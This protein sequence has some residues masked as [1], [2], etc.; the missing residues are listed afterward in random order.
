MFLWTSLIIDDML[1]TWMLGDCWSALSIDLEVVNVSR[2]FE[3]DD[4]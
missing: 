2:R 4:Y 1:C 3:I